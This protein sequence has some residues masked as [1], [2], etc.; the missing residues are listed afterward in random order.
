MATP[1]RVF[2][3]AVLTFWETDLDDPEP[4][5]LLLVSDSERSV[6]TVTWVEKVLAISPRAR[7]SAEARSSPIPTPTRNCSRGYSMLSPS[8]QSGRGFLG[9]AHAPALSV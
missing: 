2:W 4:C 8:T 6:L 1:S 5:P 9:S 7:S 3:E